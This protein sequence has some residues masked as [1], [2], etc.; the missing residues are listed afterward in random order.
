MQTNLASLTAL[1]NRYYKATTGATAS[2]WIRDKAASVSLLLDV[3]LSSANDS[4]NS[5]SQRMDVP[6]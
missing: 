2:T 5:I 3:V 4:S 6:T 1:N